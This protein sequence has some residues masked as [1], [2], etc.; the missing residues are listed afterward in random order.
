MRTPSSR[1]PARRCRGIS[2]GRA[3]AGF[4]AL[5]VLLLVIAGPRVIAAPG[6][7]GMVPENAGA[8]LL[9][10][11][12]IF[13]P[14]SEA[15]AARRR[16]IE[17]PGRDGKVA[18]QTNIQGGAL[19]LVFSNGAGSGATLATAGTFIIKRSLRDGSFVQAKVFLQSDPGCYLRVS[20]LSGSRSRMSVFLF[21]QPFQ[22]D[23]V[24]PAGFETLLTAPF[25][26]L[27]ELTRDG[28]GLVPG[29]PPAA[30]GRGRASRA[31][32]GGAAEAPAPAGRRGG[33][34]DGRGR[35]VRLH[36]QRPSAAGS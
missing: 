11:D 2:S 16:L 20:P 26:R 30:R 1:E 21:G 19:F 8:R 12:T 36:R 28:G 13:A 5:A 33:R 25:S 23:I 27:V 35:K 9:L 32:R 17:Q 18:F 3:A 4:A 24:V 34:G 31:D 15:A 29:P 22:E 7:A 14:V 6:P 10:K